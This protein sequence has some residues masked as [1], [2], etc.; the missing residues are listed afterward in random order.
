ML[1][2]ALSRS[3]CKQGIG[4]DYEMMK[5]TGVRSTMQAVFCV[6]IIKSNSNAMLL[7][8]ITCQIRVSL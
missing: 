4:F 6:E 1:L 3:A 7:Q 8:I 5:R 2:G